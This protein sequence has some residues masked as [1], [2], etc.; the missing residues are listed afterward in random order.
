[1]AAAPPERAREVVS[2]AQGKDGD[3]RRVVE[4]QRVERREHP[5]HGTV[6]AADQHAEAAHSAE[7]GEGRIDETLPHREVHHLVHAQQ[8]AQLRERRLAVPPAGRRV[9]EDEQRR[10]LVRAGCRVVKDEG[11]RVGQ[12]R[13][14][15]EIAGGGRAK[16]R[17]D[18]PRRFG[19]HAPH[20][21]ATALARCRVAVG[22]SLTVG[23]GSGSG[24]GGGS[25]EGERGRGVTYGTAGARG[26]GWDHRRSKHDGIGG[27]HEPA[28]VLPSPSRRFDGPQQL[29]VGGRGPNK[30]YD[31]HGRQRGEDQQA[32]VEERV[33]MRM[34]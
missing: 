13:G 1:V 12:W 6:A 18:E 19:G 3:G 11:V 10:A 8:G 16:P 28:D 23:R 31:P 21:S 27:Q 34:R 24:E 25:G 7:G 33:R 32:G 15:C 26:G 9:D 14:R 22:A 5:A 20:D 17:G 30:T 2:R 4:P 29:G